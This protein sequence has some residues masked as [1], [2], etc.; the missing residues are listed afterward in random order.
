MRIGIVQMN[1]G[2]SVDKNLNRMSEWVAEAA[3]GGADLIAFP[4]MAYL[5]GG[6]AIWQ[7]WIDR[8]DEIVTRV[9]ELAKR[10]RIALHLGSLREPGTLSGR[11]FNTSVL[12]SSE[13]KV[14]AKYRKVFLFRAYVADRA[15]EE[16]KYAD[17]G[18]EIVVHEPFGFA[19]CFD[20]RFPELFRSLSHQGAKIIFLPSAFTVPTGRAH[21]ETLLRAR[22]IENQCFI[23]APDLVGKLGDG[24]TAYGHSM[25]ISPWGEI[26][27]EFNGEEE[28]VRVVDLD[29]DAINR[30]NEIVSALSCR[31]DDLFPPVGSQ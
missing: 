18:S 22:A 15:Y 14:L 13:G 12:I 17:A 27:A 7:P 30:A 31:R 25:V 10:H 26:V 3:S 8:Y 29:F 5:T 4:E 20:L 9:S 1:S 19:I 11:Y 6:V 2:S 16:S 23:V 21:W 24:N 28:G